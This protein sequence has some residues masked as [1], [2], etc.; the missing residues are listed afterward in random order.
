V[1]GNILLYVKSGKVFI[2][3]RT[4]G[5]YGHPCSG[6]RKAAQTFHN[7]KPEDQKAIDLLKEAGQNL[8]IIDLTNCSFAT[9]LMAKMKGINE[10]PTLVMNGRKIKG[11]ENIAQI[12]LEIKH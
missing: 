8:Q 10:T 9:Q 4:E 3:P 11:L 5:I 1:T 12:L 6:A 7:Y 2:V